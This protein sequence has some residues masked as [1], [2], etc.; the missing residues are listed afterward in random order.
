MGYKIG[1]VSQK[2]GVGKST[3][4]R[5]LAVE[6]ALNGWK[7]KIADMDSKQK[8]CIEWAARR[9]ENTIEPIIEVQN[10]G[11]VSDAL[12]QQD[13]YDLIIFDGVGQA[14]AQ[15]L[16]IA[17]ASDIIVLPS[18]LSADDLV[19][20]I[21]LANEMVS[22]GI[23]RNQIGFALSRVGRSERE[24]DIAIEDIST[25]YKYL[26]RI[27]EKTSITLAHDTGRAANETRYDTITK[28]VDELIQGVVDL[29]NERINKG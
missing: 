24:L 20:Q 5:A 13:M 22:K 9:I 17:R 10:F 7:V 28:T 11:R 16:E 14:D 15:T 27:D 26:G 2:G 12:S 25:R 18:G 29:L 4:T 3:I 21:K 23:D 6:Y 1:V 19:P 8:T